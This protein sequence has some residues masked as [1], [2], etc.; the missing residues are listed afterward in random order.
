MKQSKTKK[1]STA[2]PIKPII[3]DRNRLNWIT[4]CSNAQELHPNHTLTIGQCFNWRNI[5]HYDGYCCWIGQV[6]QFSLLIRQNAEHTQY[7]HLQESLISHLSANYNSC[8]LFNFLYDYFQLKHSLTPLY[9]A[10]SDSCPRMKQ[11][12]ETLPGVR[13]IRQDPW[14]CL[15][16]F[17][18]SSNNNI[19]RISQMLD[20]LRYHYG[21]YKCSLYIDTNGDNERIW[22]VKY[23]PNHTVELS[24]ST[25]SSPIRDHNEVISKMIGNSP[26]VI[27]N[28]SKKKK[29]DKKEL[30]NDTVSMECSNLP[31]PMVYHLYEFP[32]ID[33]LAEANEDD[34][35][36][37][38]M[39]YRAKFIIGS[40]KYIKNKMTSNSS[41]NNNDNNWLIQLRNHGLNNNDSSTADYMNMNDRNRLYVQQ[42][43]LN[44]PGVG[45]K[46]A[47]CVAL[48]SLD[49][50]SAI[51]VD[52]HVWQIAIRDYAP[53]LQMS[54]SL[55]PMI[56]EQVGNVFRER[57]SSDQKYAGWAHS[58]LFAAELSQF[59]E[60]LP[61]EMQANMKQF[62]EEQQLI[63]KQNKI[64]KIN[65]K[66][67]KMNERN[68]INEDLIIES[69]IKLNTKKRKIIAKN[70]KTES[71]EIEKKPSKKLKKINNKN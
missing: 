9:S 46:V 50:S 52:T 33:A 61:I 4:I 53:A 43:L 65:S 30:L 48:F 54:K 14:E 69:T 62:T 22:N 3:K 28:N 71:V 59:R 6:G 57:F 19:A 16:S 34:L 47:D 8:D 64:N 66:K 60:K 7:A 21:K 25:L 37:L 10:W 12:T 23:D 31:K 70:E 13:V 58:I 63:K 45:R 44:L 2:K 24:S 36:T 18:C 26:V 68:D 29:L 40:A 39:G 56:Y 55:T 51:P 35:R 27:S 38:G 15:I 42:E 49:Q 11:V 20:K 1:E 5:E 67:A 17:I 41:N 32:T